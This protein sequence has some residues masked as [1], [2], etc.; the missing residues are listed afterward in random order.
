MYSIGFI[1]ILILLPASDVDWWAVAI[2]AYIL[3]AI[4]SFIPVFKVLIKKID[5]NDGGTSFDSCPHFSDEHK[6]LLNQHYS[7]LVGTLKFWKNRAERHRRFHLYTICWTIPI[8]I[9]IPIVTQLID[10]SPMSKAFLTVM[11]CHMALLIGFHRGMK[12]ENNYKAFRH[13]ESEFYDLYRR[14]LD[15][16]KTF[17]ETED[18]QLEN[19][20]SEAEKIR[21]IVRSAEIDNF[22]SIE[23]DNKG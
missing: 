12:I 10:V 9:L 2:V 4:S 8:S 18:V 13:G 3:V 22:P 16:P 1:A 23:E 21:K 7:R 19:Y 14:L 11:S 6:E 5:L 17:G 15:R 20:F